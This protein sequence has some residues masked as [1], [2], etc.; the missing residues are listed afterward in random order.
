MI[1][2]RI[3][4]AQYGL[5][6]LLQELKVEV[7]FCP[8]QY[9]PIW[10][11]LQKRSNFNFGG[12]NMKKTCV[13]AVVLFVCLGVVGHA[14][15]L[16]VTNG[17]TLQFKADGTLFADDAGTISVTDG[18]TVGVWK[19]AVGSIFGGDATQGDGSGLQ[20]T[21]HTNVINGL[22]VVRFDGA[23]DYMANSA[24]V[25]TFLGASSWTSFA[26]FHARSVSAT[27]GLGYNSQAVWR[28]SGQ[29]LGMPVRSDTGTNLVMAYSYSGV[30]PPAQAFDTNQF[31]FAIASLGSGLVSIQAAVAGSGNPGSP[32][33]A[34][35]GN[36]TGGI[37]QIGKGQGV[38]DGDI[39]ELLFYNRTL[40]PSEI[41]SVT[42]Y[43][44][45]KYALN[46][47]PAVVPEPSTM[48]LLT[49]AACAIL[50]RRSNRA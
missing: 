25:T 32:T 42:T 40:S 29:N 12:N 21:F 48:A 18:S 50:R 30:N 33:S 28:D 19:D 17:L 35:G 5:H 43:L 23:N 22:P 44:N 6:V 34:T 7:L 46:I 2:Q 11:I 26:V 15:T 45:D 4:R 9:D 3:P 16:S 36:T 27:D 41:D 13:G 31:T 37:L 10:A 38:F 8:F 47:L 1:D 24:A 39:A 49:I 20:P 14:A